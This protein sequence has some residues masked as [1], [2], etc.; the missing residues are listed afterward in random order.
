M[1][2]IKWDEIPAEQINPSF[3]RR[4]AWDGKIMIGQTLVKQGYQVPLHAHASEQI[5]WVM[6]G[7]WRF[8]IDGKSVLVSA[9]EMITIPSNM[10]HSAYAVEDLVAYDIFTPPREDWLSGSDAYLRHGG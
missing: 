1:K 6:R 7:A 9:N 5:T 2:H 3:V 4:L 8:E 10:P